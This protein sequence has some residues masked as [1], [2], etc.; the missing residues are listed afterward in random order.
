MFPALA[1][2]LLAIALWLGH[3]ATRPAHFRV[4]RSAVIKAPVEKVF[5][6]INDLRSFNTWNPW[7]RKDPSVKGRYSGAEQGVGAAYAWDGRKAGAG[8]LEITATEAP[9]RVAMRLDVLR[10][11]EVQRSAEFMLRPEG[12][13]LTI[14]TWSLQGPS[15]YRA[16]LASLVIDP[17]AVIGRDFEAGLANLRALAEARRPTWPDAGP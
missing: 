3:A 16:R 6:L 14:V 12:E 11:H 15:N 8:R 1:L 4:A 9:R 17:D 10:P 5:A 13:H 7:E 2:L